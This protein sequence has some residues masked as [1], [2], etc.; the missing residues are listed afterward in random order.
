M[1]TTIKLLAVICF[2][3]ALAGNVQAQTARLVH[4]QGSIMNP[5]GEAFSGK[6]NLEFKIYKGARDAAPVWS[7][8]HKDVEVTDGNYEV[9]LGSRTPLR[10]SFYEYFLEVT[11]NVAAEQQSRRMI[12]GSGYNYRLSFLFAAY[13]IVWLALFLYVLS[14][15]RRQRK[16]SA[17]LETMLR[18]TATSTA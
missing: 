18:E 14:I 8:L 6:C 13:T 3:V 11:P 4:Y 15:A 1:N 16:I 9:F 17:E 5:E 12:V 10:L 2:G 7:E